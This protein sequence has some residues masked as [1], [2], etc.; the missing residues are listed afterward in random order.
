[1]KLAAKRAGLN[2]AAATL[3]NLT[4]RR[5]LPVFGNLAVDEVTRHNPAPSGLP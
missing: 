1:M 5:E 2:I 3:A 4:E